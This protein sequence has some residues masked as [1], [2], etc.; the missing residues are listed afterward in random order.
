M[1]RF[2][3]WFRMALLYDF[4]D[5]HARLWGANCRSKLSWEKGLAELATKQLGDQLAYTGRTSFGLWFKTARQC[6]ASFW[7]AVNVAVWYGL[8]AQVEPSGYCFGLFDRLAKPQVS[9]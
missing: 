7:Y 2:F 1:L 4:S 5:A 6:G 9:P 8:F 3:D